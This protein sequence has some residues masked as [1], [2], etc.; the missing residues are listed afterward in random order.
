M[1][2]KII[3]NKLEKLE[4]MCSYAELST[5]N[6]AEL[7]SLGENNNSEIR[8]RVAETL[9]CHH[10]EESEKRLLA[11]L[12]DTDVLVRSEVCDSLGFSVN[13]NVT[14]ILLDIYI[15]DSEELV[16]GY[17]VLAIGDI[18]RNINKEINNGLKETLLK[19][20][21]PDNDWLLI[22]VLRTL[23]LN[24]HKKYIDSLAIELEGSN[25]VDKIFAIS[26]FADL[27]QVMNSEEIEKL[28][29]RLSEILKKEKYRSVRSSIQ[30]LVRI[31]EKNKE[32]TGDGTVCSDEK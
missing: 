30:D 24:G 4:Q 3:Q 21:E 5:E 2:N 28:K 6:W 10:C 14:E 12:K 11:M 7:K 26:S 23:I 15:N 29:R 27:L 31:I 17:A 20:L 25:Y 32:K 1:K 19:H 13:E 9:G 18:Y 22:A 8:M 16:R